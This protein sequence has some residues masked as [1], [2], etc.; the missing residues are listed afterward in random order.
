MLFWNA[1][2]PW[3]TYLLLPYDLAS[4]QPENLL[5]LLEIF[6]PIIFIRG[7]FF[8]TFFMFPVISV[9]PPLFFLS[10]VEIKFSLPLPLF[11]KI[12]VS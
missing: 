2:V 11:S 6:T 5:S 12:Q 7:K 10:F 3:P 9:K 8:Q 4:V 1:D